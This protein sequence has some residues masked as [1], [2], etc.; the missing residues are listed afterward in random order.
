MISHP[1]VELRLEAYAEGALDPSLVEKISGWLKE[2]W[3]VTW[4]VSVPTRASFEHP[5]R[6]HAV[7]P[8]PADQTPQ[9]LH[10]TIAAR[11]MA[12]DPALTLR[13]RTRW[14]FPQT[15]NEQEVYEER[16]KPA[17]K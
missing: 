10:R 17:R 13:Y 1:P 3:P 9:A 4:D 8:L 2:K 14:D 11:L 16:W 7:V 15:P 5:A 6:W 12:L